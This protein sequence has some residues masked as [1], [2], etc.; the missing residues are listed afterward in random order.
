MQQNSKIVKFVKKHKKT[1]LSTSA[2]FYVFLVIIGWQIRF[3]V[4]SID[5]YDRSELIG[6]ILICAP[7]FFVFFR[8]SHFFFTFPVVPRFELYNIR[9]NPTTKPKIKTTT[10]LSLNRL[11]SV[12]CLIVF[13]VELSRKTLRHNLLS[14]LLTVGFALLGDSR[15]QRRVGRPS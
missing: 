8:R 5:L 13:C 9:S 12:C 10:S 11:H 6:L 1:I 14:L 4:Y 7:L 15:R 3:C 2:L